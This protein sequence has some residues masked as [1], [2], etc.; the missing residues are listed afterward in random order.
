[1]RYVLL[2]VLALA[3]NLC[4]LEPANVLVVYND[5]MEGSKEIAEYYAGLRGIPAG[6]IFK[7]S[8]SQ[9]EEI[10]RE[11]FNT[12]IWAPISEYVLKHDNILCIVP[13]RGVP[14][15][16]KRTLKP[17]G[18]F[19]G[20]D[21]ASV[22]S[23]LMLI[24]DG[25]LQTDAAKENPFLRSDR[26]L[27]LEDKVLVVSRLDGATVELCKGL[28]EKAILAEALTP[29]GHSYLDTRGLTG[30]DGYQQRDDTM[31]LT[32]EAWKKLGIPFS[33]DE[34]PEV[35]D[36]STLKDMLHYQAW[37]AG[38]QT[39]KGKV[40]FRTGGIDVHLHS[41]SANTVRG[42]TSNWVGPILSWNA[43]CTYGTV[44]EPYTIGYPYEEIMWDRIAEGW[45][46][47]E[48]G[49]AANHLLSWQ[50]VFVGDPLYRP[51]A[52]GWK[53]RKERARKA[54][55]NRLVPGAEAVDEAELVLLDACVKLL[56][57]R[58]DEIKSLVRKDPKAALA[59]FDDARFL[60]SGL[61]QDAWLAALAKPFEDELLARIDAM[62]AA[63]KLDLKNTTELE[64]ALADWKDL[65]VYEKLVALRDELAAEQEK[66][67]A[68]LL[69]K[70]NSSA[71]SKRWLRA[72]RE[73]A[74][75]AAYRLAPS[76]VEANALLATLKPNMEGVKADADKE[77]KPDVDKAQGLFERKKYPDAKKALGDEWRYFPE[78]DQRKA[79]EALSKKIEAEL[80]KGS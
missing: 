58:A 51:Y 80:A 69:K 47:G 10:T 35:Q 52:K 60:V 45:Q 55:S 8:A 46:Y 1:M 63:A 73:A 70:A 17:E 16:V 4:A 77:L 62:K 29:E 6:Q 18:S 61:G 34:K 41:F 64:A 12:T 14:L 78:C 5:K 74:E 28:V 24:R 26:A 48:A 19:K 65:P 21:E 43:T 66:D 71:K 11:E 67:S 20:H 7:I 25:E 44:Y 75:A 76:A 27:T 49:M 32:A 79:A 50:S 54:L 31:E 37:Y 68:K 38:S 22:D 23:E 39:P 57:A 72:W 53:E 40:K 3:G 36:L 30:G 2:L 9:Q 15:K 59:L 56:N 33:H 13:C 42:T